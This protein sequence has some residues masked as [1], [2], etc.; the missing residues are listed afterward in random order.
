MNIEHPT[1]ARIPGL[2][3]LWGLA[4]GDPAAFTDCFFRTAFSPARC[5]CVTEGEGILA[6]AYWFDTEFSG[7]KAAYVY[8][9]ATAPDHRGQGLCKRLMDAI[10][11]HLQKEG[12]AGVM[13]VPGDDSLRQMYEKMGYANFG[14]MEQLDIHAGGNAVPIRDI[15][16]EEF[17]RLRRQYLPADGV[18]Q[19]GENLRFLAS[20]YRFYQAENCLLAAAG[21]KEDLFIPEFLG[22]ITAVPGI[23]TALGAKKGLIR[24]SGSVPFAM[25]HSLQNSQTPGYFAFAFD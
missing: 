24:R 22:D 20:F 21:T 16:P 10:H 25:Y 14:G 6:A 9:V 5:L 13:L 23:L 3:V 4:F 11:S 19:E 15:S 17:C 1:P 18:V 8:A 2:K 7:L 12:Y